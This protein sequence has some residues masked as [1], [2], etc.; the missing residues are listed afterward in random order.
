MTSTNVPQ[1][2][3]VETAIAVKLDAALAPLQ[4]AVVNE[5]YMHSV[6]AGSE[7]HFKVVVVS[8]AF[9]GQNPVARHRSVYAILK[10]EIAGGIHALSIE[11][12]TPQEWENLGG[13]IAASPP[14]LGGSK[15]EQ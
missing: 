9:A 7:S 12:R 14:C 13:K 2:G 15:A 3:P 1:S 6:P 4:L 5:S 8:D 11:A 10:D